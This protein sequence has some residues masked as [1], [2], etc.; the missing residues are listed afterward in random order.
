MSRVSVFTKD[1]PPPRVGIYSQAT[2]AGGFVWC[3][4]SLPADPE[5]GAIIE[6]DIQTHT[7]QCIKNLAAV[8]LAAGSSI[9]DVIKVNV[10]LLDMKDFDAMNE[11]YKTYWGEQ[12]P[13]RTCVVV[14][15]IP[16]GSDVE[17]ECVA[18]V[19][20]PAP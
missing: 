12:K 7:H 5:T 2:V 17:I 11:V 15:T 4:G 10:Y 9:N 13:S 8:L 16:R 19:S 14:K 3:S 6:G 18:V 1:A 20:G